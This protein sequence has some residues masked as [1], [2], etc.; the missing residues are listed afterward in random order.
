MLG[1]LPFTSRRNLFGAANQT[2]PELSDRFVH[3]M[4]IFFFLEIGLHLGRGGVFRPDAFEKR[5]DL[6][7][8]ERLGLSD[9]EYG[10]K[11]DGKESKF[12]RHGFLKNPPAMRFHA[13]K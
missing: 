4:N 10:Q 7:R 3:Q 12:G 9:V 11:Q 1:E 8:R 2:L 13:E 6:V 5:L